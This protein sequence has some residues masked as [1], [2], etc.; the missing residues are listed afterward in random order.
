MAFALPN[1][2]VWDLVSRHPSINHDHDPYDT[3][4]NH[5][6]AAVT[7][8]ALA[9]TTTKLSPKATEGEEEERMEEKGKEEGKKS[10]VRTHPV[11]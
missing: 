6:A 11:S 8:A 4:I 9:T 1:L 5:G 10:K 2:A 3:S 7:T